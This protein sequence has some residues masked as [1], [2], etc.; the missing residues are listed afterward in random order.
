MFE[1]NPKGN[2]KNG[3]YMNIR[4]DFADEIILKNT[5]EYTKKVENYKYVKKTN[6]QILKDKSFQGKM[7]NRNRFCL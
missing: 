6:I 1:I 5:K 2:N 4:T 7:C 3:D